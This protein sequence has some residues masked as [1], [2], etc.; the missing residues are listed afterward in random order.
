[1]QLTNHKIFTHTFNITLTSLFILQLSKSNTSSK[2]YKDQTKQ[3]RV[4]DT[5]TKTH[6]KPP[7]STPTA[8]RPRPTALFCSPPSVRPVT[9]PSMQF[10]TK[11]TDFVVVVANKYL[12]HD[13]TGNVTH[14]LYIANYILTAKCDIW[15][16]YPSNIDNA[17]I[18]K[19]QKSLAPN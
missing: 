7:Y 1:V 14:S 12:P 15:Y 9:A 10:H 4:L 5:L 18:Y 8:N 17:N 13:R 19:P 6:A 11:P 3:I 16:A 2:L